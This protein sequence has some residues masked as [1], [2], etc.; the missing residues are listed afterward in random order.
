[1]ES[2]E[3]GVPVGRQ[4]RERAVAA[5]GAPDYQ[6]RLAGA[7]EAPPTRR[8]SMSEETTLDPTTQG[9][10][11]WLPERRFR[12]EDSQMLWFHDL[13]PNGPP[14]TPMGASLHHWP[15]GTKFASEYLQ[16]P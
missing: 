14:S 4:E 1:M 11:E 8:K 5:A 15:R 10:V 12:Q 3:A 9:Q 7:L 2:E 6:S 13:L 16:F